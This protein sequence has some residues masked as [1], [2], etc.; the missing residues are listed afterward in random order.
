MNDLDKEIKALKEQGLSVR[1]IAAKVGLSKS[2]VSRKLQIITKSWLSPRWTVIQGGSQGPV[3]VFGAIQEPDAATLLALY[4]DS[5]Y[6]CAKWL[7]D[8]ISSIPLRVYVTT[9]TGQPK[10]KCLVAPVSKSATLDHLENMDIKEVLE[11]PFKDL[12]EHP[13]PDMTKH[14]MLRLIDL[15]MSLTGNSY[16]NKV[17]ADDGLPESL[18]PLEPDKMRQAYSDGGHFIGWWMGT[19]SGN[20]LY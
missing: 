1:D 12:L 17:R 16:L 5:V 4:D 11:H 10:P 7:S 13:N 20:Y 6:A 18:W 14:E 15:D 3:D 9:A 8:T 19:N 2:T